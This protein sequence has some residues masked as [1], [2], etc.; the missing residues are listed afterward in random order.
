MEKKIKRKI[1]SKSNH[2]FSRAGSTAA[3][4]GEGVDDGG[5]K[6]AEGDEAK[7]DEDRR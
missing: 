1:Q 5:S 6:D 3:T 7:I 2:A 4:G